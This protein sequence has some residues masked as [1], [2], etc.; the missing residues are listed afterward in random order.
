MYNL[1]TTATTNKVTVIVIVIIS[2]AVDEHRNNGDCSSPVCWVLQHD[3]DSSVPWRKV[4]GTHTARR[5]PLRKIHH[6][7]S[8]FCTIPGMFSLFRHCSFVYFR[9]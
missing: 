2:R 1:S 5:L 9:L 8:R 6:H 4:L 3:T 7:G